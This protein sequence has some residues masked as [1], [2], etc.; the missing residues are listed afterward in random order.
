MTPEKPARRR[1]STDPFVAMLSIC[2]PVHMAYI[3][4]ERETTPTHTPSVDFQYA[5]GFHW[6]FFL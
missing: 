6:T 4:S 5:G 2:L 1:G 3:R